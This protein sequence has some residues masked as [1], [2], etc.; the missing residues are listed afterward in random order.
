M[1]GWHSLDIFHHLSSLPFVLVHSNNFQ[2]FELF[3]GLTQLIILTVAFWEEYMTEHH[4]VIAHWNRH[5]DTSVMGQLD[6]SFS[7]RR[8]RGSRFTLFCIKNEYFNKREMCSM[9]KI[10]L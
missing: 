10:I 9:N 2:K 6:L 1:V 7:D 4:S 8:R 5:E 3:M